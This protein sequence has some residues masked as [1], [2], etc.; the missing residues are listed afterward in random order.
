M[1]FDSGVCVD[2]CPSVLVRLF[3]CASAVQ[4]FEPLDEFGDAFIDLDPWVVAEFFAGLADVGEGDGH[5]AGLQ[6]LAIDLGFLAQGL[7]DQFD[8]VVELDGLGFA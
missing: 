4:G 5:V 1:P 7:G 2:L 8:E 3:G 6:W